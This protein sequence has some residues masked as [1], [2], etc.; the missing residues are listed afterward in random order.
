MSEALNMDVFPRIEV[1]YNQALSYLRHESL[2]VDADTPRGY[3]LI[4]YRT[5]PLGFGK[6]VGGRINNLYPQE[7]RIRSG[8]TTPFELLE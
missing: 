3:L 8:Y 5:H 4:C 7:W 1:T 6:C 2:T